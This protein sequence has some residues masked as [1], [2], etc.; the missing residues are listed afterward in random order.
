MHD[1]RRAAHVHVHVAHSRACPPPCRRMCVKILLVFSSRSA[2]GSEGS[3]ARALHVY[4]LSKFGLRG[5][6][7]RPAAERSL[8]RAR[9]D[10]QH[11]YVCMYVQGGTIGAR[12]GVR[13]HRQYLMRGSR[14]LVAAIYAPHAQGRRNKVC[15]ARGIRRS[16]EVR[17][18]LDE[19]TARYEPGSRSDIGPSMVGLSYGRR[20]G[21]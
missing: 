18:L 20:Y 13:E 16:A 9:C 14:D 8:S 6:S 10:V 21:V 19:K 11:L 2:R 12:L 3:R 1:A 7:T 4:V 15:A 17:N 5:G